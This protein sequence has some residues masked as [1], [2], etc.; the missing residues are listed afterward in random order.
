MEG[1]TSDRQEGSEERREKINRLHQC[2][3]TIPEHGQLAIVSY[4]YLTLSNITLQ[5]IHSDWDAR[6]LED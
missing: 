4:H 2:Q 5:L 3:D 1:Q 6:R